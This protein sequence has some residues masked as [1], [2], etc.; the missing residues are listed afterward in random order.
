[1]RKIHSF[2]GSKFNLCIKWMTKKTK[3][4]FILKDKCLQPACKIYHCVCS[5]GE[6]YIEETSG[7]QMEQAQYAI[8]KMKP[9]KTFE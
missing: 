8:R 5:C 7:H 1:M 6:T 3:T 2:T 9:L 4:L